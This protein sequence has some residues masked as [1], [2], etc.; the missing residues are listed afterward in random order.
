MSG[1]DLPPIQTTRGDCPDLDPQIDSFVLELGSIVDAFQDAEVEGQRE[2]IAALAHDLAS[3][4]IVL[5][6]API[7]ESARRVSEAVVERNREALHKAV[8]D[9]TEVALRVRRGHRSAA[10]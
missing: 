6:F 1:R 2:E 10:I 7:A 8:V 5:G 9:L 3:R 4:A